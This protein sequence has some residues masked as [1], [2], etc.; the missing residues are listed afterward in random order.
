MAP[1]AVPFFCLEAP[2][3][4]PAEGR[5]YDTDP[6]CGQYCEAAGIALQQPGRAGR[7]GIDA[8]NPEHGAARDYFTPCI[9]R[10]SSGEQIN[11]TA[12]QPSPIHISSQNRCS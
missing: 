8:S 10:F 2:L 9:I 7:F 5:G 3:Y 6:H 4:H 1:F 11:A 12:A